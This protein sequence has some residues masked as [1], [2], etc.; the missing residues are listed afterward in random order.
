MS[1]CVGMRAIRLHGDTSTL[2]FHLPL[3]GGEGGCVCASIQGGVKRLPAC[4]G[5][6]VF[7]F[8]PSAGTSG[9]RTG[10]KEW[11]LKKEEKTTER[12]ERKMADASE[13]TP[14]VTTR[15]YD[16]AAPPPPWRMEAEPTP[17]CVKVCGGESQECHRRPFLGVWSGRRRA[18]RVMIFCVW[19]DCRKGIQLGEGLTRGVPRGPIPARCVCSVWV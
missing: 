8:R 15:E 4:I 19:K 5:Q 1:E 16:A 12:K 7:R 3:R 11:I 6:T 14:S 10:G 18:D 13:C 2:S 17:E 9:G